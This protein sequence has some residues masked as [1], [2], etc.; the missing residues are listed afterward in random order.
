MNCPDCNPVRGVHAPYC[1]ERC[2]EWARRHLEEFE[3]SLPEPAVKAAP[4][5]GVMIEF[6]MPEDAA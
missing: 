3:K 6:E 5:G 4:L 1:P 2:R